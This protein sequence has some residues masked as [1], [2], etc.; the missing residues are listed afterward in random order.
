MINKEEFIKMFPTPEDFKEKLKP[1]TIFKYYDR[2]YYEIRGYMDDEFLDG[3]KI[4]LVALRS[5]VRYKEGRKWIM[6]WSYTM[7][8]IFDFYSVYEFCSRE[9]G[10]DFIKESWD[11]VIKTKANESNR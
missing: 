7:Q 4:T 9:F 11:E 2:T 10:D 3:E 5:C 6:H 8:E 1:G